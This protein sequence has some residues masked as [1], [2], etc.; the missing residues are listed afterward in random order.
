MLSTLTAIATWPAGGFGDLQRTYDLAVPAWDVTAAIEA[1]V[2]VDPLLL[3]VSDALRRPRWQ[4]VGRVV[5][6]RFE[7]YVTSKGMSGLGLVGTVEEQPTGSR[8]VTRVAWTGPTR[9][10]PPAFTVCVLVGMIAVASRVA[11]TE[12]AADAW[13][14]VALGAI[15]S[16]IHVASMLVRARRARN[17]ELP[18]LFQRLDALLAAARAG[19]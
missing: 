7:I 12:A 2:A 13:T 17:D 11:R 6:Q 18:I 19:A 15:V 5:G 16:G 14:S 10:L 4:I 9:W 1:G 3:P 8:V